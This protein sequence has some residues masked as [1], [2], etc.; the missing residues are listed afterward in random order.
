MYSINYLRIG[1]IVVIMITTSLIDLI[2]GKIRNYITI[3]GIIVGLLLNI[4]SLLIFKEERW[5]LQL[6]NV[7]IVAA[8]AVIMYAAKIWAGGD[9]KTVL[10][11]ALLYPIDN[12]LMYAGVYLSLWL[13]LFFSL[14]IGYVYIVVE[15]I[16]RLIK[17]RSKI[18]IQEIKKQFLFSLRIY[19]INM[20]I[21]ILFNFCMELSVY[22][23][24]NV[25]DIY[26][27]LISFVILLIVV[28]LGIGND[29]R[30]ILITAALSIIVMIVSRGS[31]VLQSWKMYIAII[32]F[33]LIRALTQQYNYDIIP[34]QELGKG[35]IISKRM[36]FFFA[37]SKVKGL[38]TNFSE[39]LDS[40]LTQEEVDSIQR[41]SSSKY[42]MQEVE[43]VRKVPFAVFISLGLVFYYYLGVIQNAG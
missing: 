6:A 21:V 36:F 18:D 29:K 7:S 5:G 1:I 16:Y 41:W 27:T 32:A 12:Y 17:R 34:V 31:F 37:K 15:S 43:I 26:K 14:S 39:K 33:M 25:N 11:L 23:L 38:P 3:S 9:T 22:R 19:I 35:M 13:W 42:G 28:R 20:L 10:A 4:I 30:I 24:I 2:T 8:I 40:R